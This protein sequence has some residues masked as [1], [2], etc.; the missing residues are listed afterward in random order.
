MKVKPAQRIQSVEEYYFSKKLQEIAA[1]RKAGKDIINLGIGSPDLPPATEVVQALQQNCQQINVHGYQSYR[2][3]PALR[4]AF[5]EWY[6]RYFNVSLNPQTQILPLM[7]SKEGIMHLSMSFL[8][9]GDQVLV[10]DPGYP[11]YAAT[12]KLAGATV[13][14]YALKA[15]HNWLPDL[16]SLE[17]EGLSKVKIMWLNY[18]HMPTGATASHTDFSALIQFAQKHKILLC[19]D[20]PYAFI[21]N[22]RPCSILEIPGALDCCVELNSLS[23]SHAMAGWR[24]GMLA[25]SETIIQQVL[26]FKSNMDSGMYLPLQLAAIAALQLPPSW[27]EKQNQIYQQ[28]KEKAL[29]LFDH[30]GLSYESRQKGMF[31]WGKINPKYGNGYDYSNQLLYQANIFLTPGGIFGKQGENY[32]RVSLCSSVEVFKKSIQTVEAVLK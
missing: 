21:L 30:L 13:R 14:T 29:E 10:P 9:A 3:S 11:A 24:I 2:G 26:K 28:R 15:A 1:L 4:C 6:D 31:I 18:P 5:A 8:E 27:Y 17:Q 22:D 7:G 12:A 32:L 16:V 23:K 25:A 19:H 20:N